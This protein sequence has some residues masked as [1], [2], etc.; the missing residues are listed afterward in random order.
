LAEIDD[1]ILRHNDFSL[2]E[3]QEAVEAA[4]RGFF[5]KRCG[6]AR[7]RESEGQ[8]WDPALWSELTELRAVRMGVP[9]TAGGDG[10]GLVEL[11]LMCE[12]AGR[13]AAPVP[14]VESVVAARL[15]AALDHDAARAALKQVLDGAVATVVPLTGARGSRALV[16]AG[17]A[18]NL[19]LALVEGAL[20][21]IEVADPPP[22]VPNL[23]SSPLAWLDL[24][25]GI[26]LARGG[27][28]AA[29]FATALREWR[30]LT[31]ALL[32]GAGEA[33]LQL[34]VEYAK[35]RIAFGVPIG[36]FQAIAHPLADVAT[37]VTSAR[38]LTR[39]ACWFADHDPAHLR[40]LPSMAFV[41]AA[42]SAEQAGAVA[43]HVQ[44][45]FG[46]TLESDVQLFY[47]R[48]KG[49]PLVAGDRRAEVR[50]IADVLHGREVK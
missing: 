30:M 48:A 25:G 44:G 6:A 19:V 5:D 24:D 40:A 18:A 26:E 2:D 20:V 43:I 21:L 36:S 22:M 50:R 16:P 42:E 12:A 49:W 33:S 32:V 45:G 8:G 38:R 35:D 15:L 1:F 4:F 29:A 23:A 46:F 27:A 39:K 28:A 47:R 14:L 34:G 41:H 9:E 11:A 17:A 31:A 3:E 10:G 37:A 13:R 7:V